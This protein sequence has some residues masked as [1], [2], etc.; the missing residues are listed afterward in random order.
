MTKPSILQVGSYPDWD[1]TA[2][3]AAFDMHRYFD[4][5]DKPAFLKACG[6]QIRA[7]ATRGD[8]GAGAEMI[9][10]CP[11]L[12]MI[13]VYGVGYDA[14]HMPSARAR[15]IK[16]ANTPDV[17]TDDVADL[18]VG[19]ILSLS[20]GIHKAEAFVR[21]GSWS[22]GPF[23]LQRKVSGRRVGILGLGR[24]GQQIARRLA[25]F[26]MQIAYSSRNPKPGAEAWTFVGDPVDLA[27]QSDILVVALAATTETRHIVGREV[28]AA[29]G[30]N[31]MLVNISRAANVDEEALLD[32]LESR[33]L[34]GA[35]LDVFDGEPALNP[36]FLTA[37]NTLLQP[38]HGSG[39]VETRQAMGRLVRDNLTAHF[40]GRP[41]LT[42][43]S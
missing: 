41:L 11:N 16:V 26:D 28:I 20:R 38:H 23:P 14:V 21:D 43:V 6:P 3:D 2:L 15:G 13:A 34:G 12:E 35:A 1:Q 18:A 7:I 37:P 42:P 40:A 24:I 32:A 10:A 22:N 27:R 4:A 25:A 31:G 17:L 30:P 19:M 33:A 39:T 8:L 36:R 9:A 5:K 29:L